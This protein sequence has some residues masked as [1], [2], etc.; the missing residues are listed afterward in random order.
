M[1]L[2]EYNRKR[3]FAR[4]P[5]PAGTTGARRARGTAKP[6]FVIQKHMARRPHYDFRLELDGVLKSWAVP[7]G[8]S[9]DPTVKRLAV[10]VEDHP[11]EYGGFEGVIPAG[12]YGGGT[13]MLWDRGWWEPYGDPAAGY[14]KGDFKF[15]LH[16]AK[17]H[18]RWVLVRLKRRDGERGDNWLLIKERDQA[19]EP[20]SGDAITQR[21]TRSVASGREMDAIEH[22]A[23]RVWSSKGGGE[24]TTKRAGKSS[25]PAKPKPRAASALDPSTIAGAKKLASPPALEPQLAKPAD[26]PP[27]GDD[28]LHEIKFDGYRILARLRD[29][30]VR[31]DSRNGLDWTARFPEIA[32]AL[33]AL[34]VKS[35]VLDGEVVHLSDGGV[36]S[37][38]ALQDALSSGRTG[39][40]VY[41]AFDLP[42]LD[43]WDLRGAPLEARKAALRVLV[44]T[45][46]DAPL[47]RFSDHQVGR[48]REF[49]AAAGA[50][51]LEGIVSKRRDAPYRAGRGPAWLKL[52]CLER[53]DFVV[54]GFT[55][56]AGER[57]GFGA[58]LVAY[59][60]PKGKLVYA[61]RVGTGYAD[62]QLAALRSRLAKLEHKRATVK[63][64]AGLSARG[65]HWVKPELVIEV[66]FSAWT[67]DRILRAASF[68]GVRDDKAPDEVVLDPAAGRS[69]KPAPAAG[70]AVG[71]D[72]AATVGGVRITHAERVVYPDRGI[73]KLAVAEYYQ[74]VADWILPHVA[75]RPLSLLRYPEGITGER[76]FQKHPW[77]GLSDAITRIEI[78]EK[79]GPATY[80]MIEDVRGLLGLIQMGVLEIHPWGAR[81]DDP[82]KPD[83]LIFDLD[84]DEGL[85]WARVV[86]GALAVRQVLEH[87]GLTSFAKTTGGKGLHVVAPVKPTLDWDTAKEFCRAVVGK[88]AEAAPERF[89]ATMS[90][91]VRR[92]RIFIDYLRNA[93]GAT[94]VG[95]YSTR[96]RPGATV[97]APLTWDEVERGV[98]SDR[99]T[100]E[101]LPARLDRRADPWAD[102]AGT[103]QTVSRAAL[104]LLGV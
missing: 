66:G 63:L 31:L 53:E 83:R 101:N 15:V 76:F 93:R 87:V 85:A 22:A 88:L 77:G 41:V 45:A 28:W 61:G 99:F 82:D 3:D 65:V 84:P 19:A 33:A 79:D 2:R 9:L 59:H 67:T 30:K 46:A 95:A 91:A 23:D 54:V 43:G 39:G 97:S 72:G 103:R 73:T 49:F 78:A 94:A 98:R 92:G 104:R 13:V 81:A 96:A 10:H 27:L 55:K 5:E 36:S 47:L 1:G 57:V 44:E 50:H 29:G 90:K 52:K 89:T 56:P 80:M 40:L 60:D 32:D 48:G 86:E 100:I 20:G 75:R 16:G 35:A 74:T 17:L 62:K 64:P 42:Y 8:P 37:F 21:E 70:P 7:K 68:V 102:F 51:G 26:D 6:S 71:R 25:K 12:E 11:V 34:P 18:G 69:A 24:T 38:G 4:T 58:L 14:K